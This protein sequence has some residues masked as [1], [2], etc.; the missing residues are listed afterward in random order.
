MVPDAPLN[1]DENGTAA[2]AHGNWGVVIASSVG[3]GLGLSGLPFFTVGV[4]V[5][6]LHQTF[7]WAVV[8]IQAGLTVM[9]LTNIVTLPLAAWLAGR[10]G[11][12]SVALGSIVAFGL[13]FM[14]LGVLNGDLREFYLNE[15]VLSVAGAG[16]LG[17]IWARA[18]STWFVQRRGVALGVAMMG[19]GVT[20]LIAPILADQLI[21]ATGWRC[22]YLVL[23]ALPLL[24]AAPLVWA[25]FKE[26]P[27]APDVD[28]GRLRDMIAPTV[29]RQWRFWMIG[30][31]FLLVGW[32]VAGTVPNLISFLVSRGYTAA[33]GAGLA[34]FL[35]LF[36]LLGRL[37]CGALLD[38]LWAPAAA[39]IFFG[40]AAGACVLLSSEHLA[41]PIAVF[42]AAALGLAAGAEFD[43]LPYLAARYFGIERLGSVLA[44][45][46]AFFYV[47]AAC[48]PW[49][50]RYLHDLTGSYRATF[51]TGASFLGLGTIALLSLGRYPGLS[52]E[53]IPDLGVAHE[54][55]ARR[56]AE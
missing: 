32:T 26:R 40:T 11:A 29:L 14:L 6:P 23:G 46:L 38:R 17:V 54:S 30:V 37:A 36:V 28:G 44:L 20:G 55:A 41:A 24:V 48:G 4:F 49:G 18:I 35:G 43:V 21:A 56:I 9:L 42:A 34:S 25:L 2:L 19:T 27:G 3:F 22:A 8:D 16:T 5:A 53:A 12:R 1:P 13:S 31:A 51:L 10:F 15:V 52:A 7:G 39:A 45:L 33:Q 50:F 47:G